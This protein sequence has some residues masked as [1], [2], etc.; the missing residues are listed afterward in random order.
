MNENQAAHG[1]REYGHIVITHEVLS[2][3]SLSDTGQMKQYRKRLV[4]GCVQQSVL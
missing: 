2:V 3:R 1:D 4:H